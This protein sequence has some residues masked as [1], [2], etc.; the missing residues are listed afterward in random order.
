MV[1]GST[2]QQQHN[3]C[4]TGAGFN[5]QSHMI[6][7]KTTIK[8]TT[9]RNKCT[10]L[11]SCICFQDP[12]QIWSIFVCHA[13]LASWTAPSRP[14]TACRAEVC[15]H[16]HCWRNAYTCGVPWSGS[17]PAK[18]LRGMRDNGKSSE[19]LPGRKQQENGFNGFLKETWTQQDLRIKE[20]WHKRLVQATTMETF[21]WINEWRHPKVIH[22]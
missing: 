17:R 1:L 14:W 7:D 2:D 3:G 5:K 12:R 10:N 13:A 18:G 11:M 16:T 22:R 15:T 9:R 19:R 20:I 4:P 6:S 8:A 21:N